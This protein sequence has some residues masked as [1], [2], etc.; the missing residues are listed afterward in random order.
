MRIMALDVGK[1][2]TG[3]AT[4]DPL[5]VT[6]TPLQTIHHK[7]LKELLSSVLKLVEEYEVVK[8]V[9]GLPK[10][11]D[12]KEGE[13]EKFVGE[14]IRM[15]REKKI[16][17]DTVEEWFSTKEALGLLDKKSRCRKEAVD[18]KSAQIILSTYLQKMDFQAQ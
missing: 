14:F 2:R 15:L 3:V 4:S 1:R 10:R 16:L 8:V 13:M 7:N 12:G 17:V 18:S 11:T 5:G 9:V 6:A